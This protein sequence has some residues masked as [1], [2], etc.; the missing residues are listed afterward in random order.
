MYRVRGL[1]KNCVKFQV[2]FFTARFEVL[3][4]SGDGTFARC[5]SCAR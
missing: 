4:N 3:D 5:L 2:S 1:A